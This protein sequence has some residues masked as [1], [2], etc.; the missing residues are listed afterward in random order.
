VTL[1]GVIGGLLVTLGVVVLLSKVSDEGD[2]PALV[3]GLLAALAVAGLVVSLP[4]LPG[5]PATAAGVTAAFLLAAAPMGFWLQ[6]A[7]SIGFKAAASLF[8]L[9]PTAVWAAC[10]L[11]G[12]TRG[13]PVFLAGAL[14]GL[15][16]LLS[17]LAVDTGSTSSFEG[18]SSIQATLVAAAQETPD[19]VDGDG[20]PDEF[21]P[22]FV[23]PDAPEPSAPEDTDGDGIPDEFDPEPFSGTNSG[24]SDSGSGDSEFESD[25]EE[26]DPSTIVPSLFGVPFFFGVGSAGSAVGVIALLFGVGYLA[27]A[28]VLDQSER[29]GTATPFQGVGIVALLTAVSALGGD[30]GDVGTSLA[31]LVVGAGLLWL[32]VMARRRLTAWLGTVLAFS[33]VFALV[34]TIVDDEVPAGVLLAILGLGVVVAAQ[35]LLPDDDA[36]D[37]DGSMAA[38]VTAGDPPVPPGPA[39]LV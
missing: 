10:F 2:S 9:V 39:Q 8:I 14:A 22:D 4:R 37:D 36:A 13:R 15:W 20:I 25:S 30:L 6:T 34:A 3:A 26:F 24:G 29:A 12:A 23:D 7:D 1:V 16:L 28:A 5:G 27:V 32:G 33:G 21:D 18:S 38:T 17:V 31:V 19:D 35:V 11:V